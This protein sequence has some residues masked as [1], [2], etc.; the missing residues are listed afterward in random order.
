M[1]YNDKLNNTVWNSF[2]NS[3]L[4]NLQPASGTTISVN[5]GRAI[6]FLVYTGIEPSIYTIYSADSTVK[7][8]KA[9]GPNNKTLSDYHCTVTSAGSSTA[10]VTLD[11]TSANYTPQATIISIGGNNLV[12]S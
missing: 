5:V 6:L 9:F 2:K 10:K 3:R 7:T 12:Q 1:S 4:I 8:T 11:N